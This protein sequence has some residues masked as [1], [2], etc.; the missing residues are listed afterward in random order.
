MHME[1]T[2]VALRWIVEILERHRVP[3]QIGGGFA[4]HVYGSRREIADIDISI[5]EEKFNVLLS[6]IQEYLTY[7]PAQYVDPEWDLLLMTLSYQGQEIDFAGSN[8]KKFFDQIKQDWVSFP[9]DFNSSVYKDVYGIKVPLMAKSKLIE[10]KKALGRDVDVF[11]VQ[12][13]ESL[14]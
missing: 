13:L 10:Y 5:P 6:D 4:A 11:D 2:E 8:N 7:G 1:K 14:G 9:T 12:A 3:Y